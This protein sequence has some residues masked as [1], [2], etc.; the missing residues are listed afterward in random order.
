MPTATIIGGGLAGLAAGAALAERGLSVTILESRPRLGGRAS[1][2]VDPVTGET[3]DNCQ[4]VAMGCCTNFRAFCRL[5]GIENHF[6]TA[7]RLHF[8]SPDGRKYDWQ[9]SSLP[10]PLHLMPAF[11]RLG[12]LTLR[13]KLTAYRGLRLLARRGCRGSC[14]R[15]ARRW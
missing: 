7:D 11:F 6:H 2:F 4:H 13:Q 9:A 10:A 12:Y 8:I 3:I 5:V 15:R 14:S 1:S